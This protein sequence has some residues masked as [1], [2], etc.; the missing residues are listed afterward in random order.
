MQVCENEHALSGTIVTEKEL[1]QRIHKAVAAA[2]SRMPEVLL[3]LVVD[4]S[5]YEPCVARPR[6]HDTGVIVG[7]FSR[8]PRRVIWS[9]TFDDM[10]WLLSQNVIREFAVRQLSYLADSKRHYYD[11]E[12]RINHGTNFDFTLRTGKPVALYPCDN[13]IVHE[14]D[15]SRSTWKLPFS[16][17]S[18]DAVP[19]RAV[20]L[21]NT[22]AIFDVV[23]ESS[24]LVKFIRREFNPVVHEFAK[25]IDTE[26]TML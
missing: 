8:P 21:L 9:E 3:S 5:V 20:Y 2:L 7:T 15:G 1:W 4:Y 18:I 25:L 10:L 24:N 6:Y 26:D 23:R 11:A 17:P 19:D 16:G 13:Y 12:F 22:G 14:T